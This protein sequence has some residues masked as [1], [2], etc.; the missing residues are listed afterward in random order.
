MP[1]P[2]DKTT[3]GHDGPPLGIPP[4]GDSVVDESLPRRPRVVDD[5]RIGRFEITRKL[6][7]GGMGVVYEARDTERGGE[8][9]AVKTLRSVTPKAAQRFK[10]EFRALTDVV[11]PNLVRL[12]ELFADD[13]QMYFSMERVEGVDLL[14]WVGA[15]GVA[16]DWSRDGT[17]TRGDEEYDRLRGV[18]HQLASAV[19]AI[20]AEGKLHRDL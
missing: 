15:P 8:R 7:A 5:N 20:H 3:I 12:Y 1:R 2:S 16:S 18:L 6:G 19:A 14:T 13:E 10:R 4:A 9:V 17:T 11:H